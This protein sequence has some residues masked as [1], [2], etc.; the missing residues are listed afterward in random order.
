MAYT[1]VGVINLALGRIGVERITSVDPS[2]D[3]RIQAADAVAVWDYILDEVLEAKDWKFAKRR[4]ALPQSFE[5]PPTGYSYAYILPSD[6]L[7]FA[8]S[9]KD[10]PP[11]SP[12]GYPYKIET[13]DIVADEG[14]ISEFDPAPGYADTGTKVRIGKYRALNF[15]SSKYLYITSTYKQSEASTVKIALAT[16][17]SD[18]LSV[19]AEDDTITINL[20]NATSTKNAANLIQ[21]ALRALSEVNGVDVSEWTVTE[22]VAYTAARP[23]IG[24]DSA[25]ALTNGDEVYTSILAVPASAAN[26]SYFPPAQSTYWTEVSATITKVLLM[27]YDDMNGEVVIN[28]IR[29]ITDLTVW[30]PTAINALAWRLA[31]EL[32]LIRTKG[33]TIFKM[34]EDEYEL[35]VFKTDGLNQSFD[36]VVNE[37]G[38]TEWEDAGR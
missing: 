17:S 31:K 9:V 2:V 4:V 22:S 24:E 30:F 29:R 28:Y 25:V 6:F 13:Q 27:D 20:A 10:H 5:T 37:T 21:A 33:P 1:Q 15:G 19:T 3:D 34:C 14:T 16:S 18:T 38:S 7:K 36:Y 23:I 35:A 26:S 12:T 32:S 8:R 11:V